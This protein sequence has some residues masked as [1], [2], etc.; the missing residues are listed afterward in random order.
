MNAQEMWALYSEKEH[1]S[2]EY[3]AWTFG[4]DADTLAELV[5]CGE[6]TGTSSAYVLYALEG[7]ELPKE[8]EYSVILNSNEDAVCVIRT[9]SVSV[10]PYD[11]VTEEHASREGEGDKSLAYWRRVHE[12]FFT[13]ELAEVGLSFTETMEVVCEEF[14]RV[15]P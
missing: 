9:T 5:F 15:F 1:I 3:D 10:V 7:E 4:A 14:V 2:A 6:K 8:G 13:R 11:R 12:D